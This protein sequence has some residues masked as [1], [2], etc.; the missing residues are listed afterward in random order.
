MISAVLYFF[1]LLVSIYEEK[2]TMVSFFRK[3]ILLSHVS[4]HFG[5]NTM[6]LEEHDASMSEGK[7]KCGTSFLIESQEIKF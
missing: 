7:N 3:Q 4:F 6:P 1:T 2:T 5:L